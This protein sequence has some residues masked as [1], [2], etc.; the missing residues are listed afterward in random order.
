MTSAQPTID[1][2]RVGVVIPVKAF[3]QAKERLSDLLTP[4]ERIALTKYCAEQVIRAAEKFETF[5]VCDDPQ[6]AQWARALSTQVV[7]QPEIGLNL[8]VRAGVE[9]AKSR[10][11]TL[12]IVSHS[13]LPLATDFAALLVGQTGELLNSSVTLVPDRHHDGTNIIVLPTDSG[14][15]FRY[16]KHSFDAHQQMA[17]KLGLQTR[18]LDDANLAVDIDTAEDLAFA[19]KLKNL[20]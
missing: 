15:E 13:D 9:F 17:K 6:V 16:G 18:V 14:F 8:A 20:G 19:Q 7:W 1:Y 11:K 2:S 12:A 10:G 5:V 4:A 3:D